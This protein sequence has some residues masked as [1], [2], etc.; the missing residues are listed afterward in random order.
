MYTSVVMPIKQIMR[1]LTW[2]K[3]IVSLQNLNCQEI[4]RKDQLDQ[5]DRGVKRVK[6]LNRR[7]PKIAQVQM[8]MVKLIWGNPEIISDVSYLIFTLMIRKIKVRKVKIS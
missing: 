6:M 4:Q 5:A 7:M 1:V 2:Q 3:G 8:G